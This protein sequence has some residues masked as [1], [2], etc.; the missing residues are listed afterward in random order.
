MKCDVSVP[1]ELK[2]L[3]GEVVYRF[4]RADVL[5]KNGIV[6]LALQDAGGM[7]GRVVNAGEF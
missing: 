1:N 7:T 5:V 3:L 4:G 2:F 6:T